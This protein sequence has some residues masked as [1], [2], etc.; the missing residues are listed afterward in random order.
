MLCLVSVLLCLLPPST[1]QV[2]LEIVDPASAALPARVV[3]FKQGSGPRYDGTE[4]LFSTKGQPLVLELEPGLYDICTFADNFA[5]ACKELDLKDHAIRI[6]IQM[7]FSP[8]VKMSS[9]TGR[10][11]GS[12]NPRSLKLAL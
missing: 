4:D 11:P 2:S 6:V 8:K 1:H 5:P 3:V 9:N 12:G 10:F 7:R